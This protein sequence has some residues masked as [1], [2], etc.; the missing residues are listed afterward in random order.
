MTYWQ[1]ALVRLRAIE[2]DDAEL[3]YKW[4]ADSDMGRNLDFL[5]PPTSHARVQ[6]F[7]QEQSLKGLE[8]DA[9]HWMIE[10]IDGVTIGSIN[11]HNCNS[12]YGTFSYGL[13]IDP[14]FRRKG[15]A[16]EAIKLVLRY[17]FEELRYQK[18]TVTVHSFNEASAK[19]HESLG[20]QREGTLRRMLFSEGVFHDLWYYGLTAEEWKAL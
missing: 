13:N 20:F 2:P 10:N 6:R 16:R 1:G 12:R 9:F 17:S 18:A 5:W 8:G 7:T 14:D 3:F 11:T 4:N 19:L 15:Y